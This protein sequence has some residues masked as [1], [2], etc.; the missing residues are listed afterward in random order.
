MSTERIDIKRFICD[1]CQ[2]SIEFDRTKYAGSNPLGGWYHVDG[3]LSGEITAT[4]KTES[5]DFC[6]KECLQKYFDAEKSNI[7]VLYNELLCAVY[8][9]FPGESRH[10]TAL[11]YIVQ[12]EDM[13]LE[14]EKK[15]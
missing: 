11:R 2:N 7:K 12:R 15:E 10:Q 8:S 13:A 9:K 1:Q 14:S 4:F 6:C 5:L 3:P